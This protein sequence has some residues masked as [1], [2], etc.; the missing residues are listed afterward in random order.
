MKHFLVFS[1]LI[2]YSLGTIGQNSPDFFRA[3]PVIDNNTP[4]WA[5]LMYDDN[6]NVIEVESRYRAY[7][8]TRPFVKTIHTQNHK[9]WIQRIESL[10]NEE[11]FIVQPTIEE[12]NA[13]FEELIEKYEAQP[14]MNVPGSQNGWVAMGPFETYKQNT[15]QPISWH[16]NIYAIDQS[17]TNPNILICGTEAGGVY[18]T[19]NKAQDWHLISKGEVF[20][21]GNAAV[22]IHP[23]DTNNFLLASNSRIYQT[24]NGGVTWIE[25]HNTSGTGNEF[26]YAPSNDSIVFHTSSTGLFK[27]VDG[28]LNWTQV[29]SQ[30]CSDIDF[31]PTN[32]SVAYL[33]KSNTTAKR[34]ELFRSDDGGVSWV[35]KDSNWYEPANLTNASDGGG[36]IA[37]TA[38]AP[39]VVYVC[40]IGASK[41]NDN[42]W[43]GI[44]KSSNK[45]E[46]WTD[47][48]GQDGGPYGAI[49]GTSTWNVA[50]YSS[51]YHQ[52]FYNFD[53][54]ASQSDSGRLWVATIRLS[55]STDGGQT[56]SSIGAANSTSLADIHADVQDIEVVGGDIWIASDGGVNYSDDTLASHVALNRGIHAGHFWGFNTGWNE[57][58]YTGGKY[59]DGTSGWS[60]SYGLGKT[61]N[62]G[63]VEEAS[64]Y[65]HPIESRKL[66]YRTHYASNNTSVKTI[67]LNFGDNVI[68]HPS[69]PKRP[70]ESYWVAERSGVYFDPRYADHMYIGLG[71]VIYKS[72]NGG[73]SFDTLYQFPDSNAVVYEIEISRSNPDV[74]YA[75][76]NE[77]GGYW[78]PCEV[79]KS[80]NGGVSWAK[81]TTDPTGNRRRF[82]ISIHPE[83][84]DEVWLCTPRGTNGNKV[85]STTNGGT[86]WVNR[87]TSTLNDE[88][89]TD[90]LY[91][92]GSDDIVYVT[93]QN[94][95]FAWDVNTSS[96]TDYSTALPLIAKT[97]QINPFYKDAELRLAT[98][99]RG[100]WARD[101]KD[102]LFSPIAQPI[103]YT[104]SVFCL[105]DTTQ[106]DCY[107][108]LQHNGASWNWSI[109]PTPLYISDSTIRNPQVLFGD[110]GS[111][112]VSLTVTNAQGDT[113]TKTIEDMVYVANGCNPDTV[114][115]LAMNCPTNTSYTNVPDL[116]LTQTD[117]FT[118]SA[119]IKPHSI[120]NSY[121]GIV[122]ND[123]TTA[124]LNFRANNELAYHWP[125]GAWWWS[126]GL[127]VNT[128]EW[129]H[130]ALVVTPTSIKVY[131]NGVSSTHTINAQTVDIHTLK[132]GSYKGWTSRNFNGEID[133]VCIWSRSLSQNEIRELRH[134]TRT[135]PVPY[136]DDLELYYQFNL[137]SAS[138][139]MDRVGLKHGTLA[140]T[141]EKVISTAPVGGGVSDRLLVVSN[142]IY[143]WPSSNTRIDFGST[144]PNDEVVVTRLNVLPDSLPNANPHTGHYWIV[145]NYGNINFSILDHLKLKT[146]NGQP[147]GNPGHAKLHARAENEHLNN[148]STLC[149]AD[150]FTGGYYDYT[151]T[152]GIASTKQFFIQS[153]DSLP[154]VGE[155]HVSTLSTQL[156]TYDSI[157]LEGAY[158]HNAGTYYDTFNISFG[159]DSV[160][161]TTVTL[162]SI[163]GIDTQT[164]CDS[165]TW[166]NG[167]TYTQN[168]HTATHHSNIGELCD[169]VTTLNLTMNYS[170]VYTDSI[171]SCEAIQWIDGNTYATSNNTATHVISNTAGCDSVVSLELVVH[172]VDSSVTQSGNQLSAWQSGASYQ[173]LDCEDSLSPILGDTGQTY[174]IIAT[175]SYAVQLTLNGCIDTSAC[176]D[177]VY[178]GTD[179]LN[180][181]TVRVFPNPNDGSFTISSGT[182]IQS[183]QITNALGQVVYENDLSSQQDTKIDLNLN[184]ASGMY[185]IKLELERN[186]S[187]GILIIE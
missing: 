15:T 132:I 142:S 52:G 133:E 123:G 62:I 149:G 12:E 122:I 24:L 176:F 36:K 136:D 92:G 96:W 137:P 54:E 1:F 66:L 89:L 91:Q 166:V 101:M 164:A 69:L 184:L 139:V 80:T 5:R 98:T 134:L 27:S 74:M 82:R 179:E 119:W 32:A 126:S 81:T 151:S 183:I 3:I 67:P 34:S 45:G 167:V 156:C 60:E 20:S 113:N 170:S 75:V 29:Y 44:Y 106:F 131:L 115:G 35:I 41:A 161:I 159:L 79:W 121:T 107:S 50:A 76:Y 173:W 87:T 73:A 148:W 103:T 38:A 83:D 77:L 40:L 6:P 171:E 181:E 46:S 153:A 129:S 163:T 141:A 120:Q 25:R 146:A 47:P 51:G 37:V 144:T 178:V 154:I 138:S 4:D 63:G 147:F 7:Y 28:G 158:Q 116:N 162:D 42:G 59:H 180:D 86:T 114:P 33:L 18:K 169:S 43:I 70:N 102:T 58:T 78:N 85:F 22:K 174:T 152:C 111:F 93:S 13:Y 14:P 135:N 143:T 55:E 17:L 56:F 182:G 130:V 99:G 23:T 172:D 155:Y 11:G 112:T 100:I 110:T 61:Y 127:Y 90:I 125:G 68:S 185:T 64:G 168:N 108:I 95:V 117:S 16:K 128:N 88:N 8:R 26:Q 118:I 157:F 39:D 65:V 19:S 140:G 49:N 71:N 104:D 21:G 145:N 187:T 9:H 165:F 105:R 150:N 30:R 186:T 10:V 53:M 109:T 72:T 94:G 31:H 84:E 2:I 48:D 57:D 160:Y 97:L 175:G 124:G 177:V